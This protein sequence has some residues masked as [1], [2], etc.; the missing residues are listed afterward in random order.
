MDITYLL[1]GLGFFLL[2]RFVIHAFSKL[3]GES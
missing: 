3:T 1:L 2:T